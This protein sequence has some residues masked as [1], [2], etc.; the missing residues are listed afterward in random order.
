MSG[1][2]LNRDRTA[3]WLLRA[4]AI[5]GLSLAS[6]I[7]F[8]NLGNPNPDERA[9]IFMGLSL[10]AIWC[11]LGGSLMFLLRVRFTE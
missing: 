5:F 4:L 11:V 1:F 7:G 9:I 3:L 2:V 10:I 8:L 6:M